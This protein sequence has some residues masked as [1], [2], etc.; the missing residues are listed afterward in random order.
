MGMTVGALS[1][2]VEKTTFFNDQFY[3]ILVN[4]NSVEI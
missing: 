3:E 1:L 4:D 2:H